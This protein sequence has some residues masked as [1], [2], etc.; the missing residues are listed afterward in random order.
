MHKPMIRQHRSRRSWPALPLLLALPFAPAQAVVLYDVTFDAPTHTVG[1]APAIALGPAPRDTPSSL[2]IFNPADTSATVVASHG[3]LGDRPLE[4]VAVNN[5]GGLGG[6]NLGFDLSDFGLPISRTEFS[7]DFDI[8]VEETG[9]NQVAAFL[10]APSI[11]VTRFLPNGEIRMTGRA[12][13]NDLLGTWSPGE[14]FHVSMTYSNVT[15]EW[16][17]R[18]NGGAV[19]TGVS[20]QLELDSIRIGSTTARTSLFYV[21][22]VL[23]QAFVVPEGPSV[24][25][26]LGGLATLAGAERR[27]R[28]T[29][30]PP[31]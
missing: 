5:A 7:L 27:R 10:D 31:R 24:L 17:S 3:A 21:D 11:H 4:M 22:N 8:I 18:L 15:G 16:S 20:D 2:Q 14:L 13:V 1:S 23:I 9:Q 12:G 30:R 6:L 28:R 25:L 29:E 26:M 19:S